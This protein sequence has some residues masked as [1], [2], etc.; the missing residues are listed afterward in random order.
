MGSLLGQNRA[1]M[2]EPGY[3]QG[4]QGTQ[5]SPR[6]QALISPHVCWAETAWCSRGGRLR[7]L[8]SLLVSLPLLTL[9]LPSFA[10]GCR[11]GN[12]PMELHVHDQGCKTMVSLW[13]QPTAIVQGTDWV[14]QGLASSACT[15]PHQQLC[16]VCHLPCPAFSFGEGYVCKDLMRD[17]HVQ[18]QAAHLA[19]C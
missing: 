18:A 3:H 19:F 9:S 1:G 13:P 8:H 16:T 10:E 12:V 15:P 5:V 11:E 14:P 6:T 4:L 7:E 17:G 2:Q